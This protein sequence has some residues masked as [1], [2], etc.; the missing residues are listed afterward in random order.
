[1]RYEGLAI[2][3]VGDGGIE[4]ER[5]L[6]EV[7]RGDLLDDRPCATDERVANVPLDRDYV[8][9]AE[10]ALG[11]VELE[12][13]IPVQHMERFFLALVV[14]RRVALPGEHDEQ[15]LAVLTVHDVQHGHAKLAET[16]E[17][18]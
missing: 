9:C 1:M 15:L 5:V 11:V 10:N 8:A 7:C 12:V 2:G 14:L 3:I 16:L 4:V 17:S 6:T 18:V 13:E